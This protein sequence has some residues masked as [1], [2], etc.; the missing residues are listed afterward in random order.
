MCGGLLGAGEGVVH[1]NDVC[2]SV[3][4]TRHMRLG[5][6]CVKCATLPYTASCRHTPGELTTPNYSHQQTTNKGFQQFCVDKQEF[7]LI[8]PLPSLNA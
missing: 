2:N 5:Q 8:E 4:T 6:G 7:D 3:F 1:E